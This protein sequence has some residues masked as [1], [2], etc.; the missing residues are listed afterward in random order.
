MYRTKNIK[1]CNGKGLVTYKGRPVGI[2][3]E[4]RKEKSQA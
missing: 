4:G 3:V 1:S 2:T